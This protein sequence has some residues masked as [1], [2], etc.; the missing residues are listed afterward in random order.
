MFASSSLPEQPDVFKSPMRNRNARSRA[1]TALA[2]SNTS[3]VTTVPGDA[4]E[5]DEEDEVE[6]VGIGVSSCIDSSNRG[7]STRSA[8]KACSRIAR[9]LH[10]LTLLSAFDSACDCDSATATERLESLVLE[11]R[12]WLSRG[13][14][15]QRT[16]GACKARASHSSTSCSVEKNS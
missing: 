3:S 5:E 14:C 8:T 9:C 7:G 12:E 11:S 4:Y 15:C 13:E 1:P 16:S 10:T 6:A 2:Q